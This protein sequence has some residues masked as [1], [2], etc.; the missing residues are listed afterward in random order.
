MF[1]G[2]MAVELKEPQKHLTPSALMALEGYGW[3]GNV[4]EL[5]NMIERMC[6]M[7]PRAQ[8]D[9]QDLPES[10]QAIAER[11]QSEREESDL[12]AMDEQ[13]LASGVTA[14]NLKEAKADFEKASLSKNWK[15]LVGTFPR[16][17]KP[18]ALNEAIFI[19]N[20]ALTISTRS[21]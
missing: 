8:V 15:N 4:R 18:S 6:I 14:S 10:L 3:P 13:S 5:K 20:F 9:L 16:R 21:V 12:A 2:H 19:E 11:V 17:P 1:L 7:V